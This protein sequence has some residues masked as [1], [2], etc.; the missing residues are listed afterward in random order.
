MKYQLT[1]IQ[2]D[3]PFLKDVIEKTADGILLLDNTSR[4]R[5]INPAAAQMFA[6]PAEELVGEAFGF[7]VVAGGMMEI[8]ILRPGG[9]HLVAE[10]RVA[11]TTWQENPALLV[12]LR[13]VSARKELEQQLR[14]A[15]KMEA[16]GRLAGGVAHDF[17]N[18]LTAIIGHSEVA[19]ARKDCCEE[20]REDLAEI[21]RTAEHAASLTRRLFRSPASTWFAHRC[22]ISTTFSWQRRGMVASMLGENVKFVLSLDPQLGN[23]SAIPCRSNRCS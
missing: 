19:M 4:V 17:N 18:L 13:D 20:V 14:H 23:V 8:D 5:F 15:Q 6:R 2:S 16:V 11:A 1:A 21:R 3:Q 10:V 22:S 9:Q 12:N 7:P